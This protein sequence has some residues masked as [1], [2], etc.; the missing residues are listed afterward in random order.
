MRMAWNK[1]LVGA[2]PGAVGMNEMDLFSL[3]LRGVTFISTECYS[4][5]RL[6]LQLD[7]RCFKAVIFWKQ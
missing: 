4:M 7:F 5:S 1:D 6:L 3:T 2:L